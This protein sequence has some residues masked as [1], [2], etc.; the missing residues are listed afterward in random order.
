MFGLFKKKK[1]K[2]AAE[3]FA[4]NL[5]GPMSLAVAIAE[6]VSEYARGVRSRAIEYPAHRRQNKNVPHIWNDFRLEALERMFNYGQADLMML[7]DFRKQ[8]DL[9]NA[10]T[11]NAPHF[12]DTQPTDEALRDTWSAVWQ[13]YAC[14]DSVGTELGDAKTDREGLR[15]QGKT[16]F[17]DFMERM[18]D[19]QVAWAYYSTSS[20]AAMPSTIIEMLW[21]DVTDKTKS[22]A[23][24][25]VFGPNQEAGIAY[26][27][28]LIAKDGKPRDVEYMKTTIDKMRS[29]RQPEE[30]RW[31]K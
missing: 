10:L 30:C 19:L 28:G 12:R 11:T 29:A 23:M 18:K 14:I 13:V 7:A 17:D 25:A 22:I 1:R 26:M 6:S 31:V 3:Q 16:I 5:F 24:S 9:L 20:T 4:D 2:D 21:Q 27:L 15:L 8:R